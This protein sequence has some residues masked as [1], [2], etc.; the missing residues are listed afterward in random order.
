MSTALALRSFNWVSPPGQTIK[1]LMLMKNISHESLVQNTGLDSE[2]L[3][4][5]YSGHIELDKGKIDILSS[6]LNV[7][8]SFLINRQEEY[9]KS[10]NEIIDTETKKWV[11]TLPVNEMKKYNWITDTKDSTN[12]CLKF[13]NIKDVFEWKQLSN[14]L[15]SGTNFKKSS[16]FESKSNN[17]ITWIRQGELEASKI[18]NNN[19]FRKKEFEENLTEFKKITRIKRPID[20]LPELS[21]CCS[22]FGVKL[23]ILPSPKKCSIS[24]LAR[25]TND[26][27]AIIQLSFR[28]LSDDHFWF[29]FFHEAAHLIMHSD[30]KLHIDTDHK[31]INQIE[32]EA[33]SYASSILIPYDLEKELPRI[34]RN[35]RSILEFSAQCNISPGILVGQLQK[36]ELISYSYLNNI[37]K[38]YSWD[39]IQL[40]INKIII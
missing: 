14:Q 1:D 18:G 34:K 20:F 22:E 26:G 32:Q 37:K 40:G 24:G 10:K 9:L 2:T 6:L 19:S 35:A 30:T 4:K 21:K 5:I 3:I 15:L 12:E 13:F 36:R 17:I 33:N 31:E 39:D 7:S 11:S 29:T 23:V 8:S 38:R 28:Y 16:A 25:V 27:S